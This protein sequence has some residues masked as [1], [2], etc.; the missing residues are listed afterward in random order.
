MTNT[1]K[2]EV[3]AGFTRNMGN[4]ESLRIDLGLGD[5]QRDGEGVDDAF[6]RVYAKIE[7]QLLEK[8]ERATRELVELDE[9]LR[10]EYLNRGK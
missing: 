6:E 9:R 8:V 2:I 7:Q 10:K 1:T 3:S 4:F 5:Y